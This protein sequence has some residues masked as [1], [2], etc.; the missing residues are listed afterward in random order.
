MSLENELS[1]ILCEYLCSNYIKVELLTNC[2]VG[3]FHINGTLK[4]TLRHLWINCCHGIYG[5]GGF[6]WEKADSN[7]AS[8]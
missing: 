8:L 3:I 7:I 1:S 4:Q 2:S 5:T 6:A